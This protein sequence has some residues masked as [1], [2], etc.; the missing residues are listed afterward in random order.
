MNINTATRDQRLA[1]V[2]A[3]DTWE[4]KSSGRTVTITA[5]ERV[6]EDGYFTVAFTDDKGKARSRWLPYFLQNFVFVSRDGEVPIMSALVK[7]LDSWDDA[8]LARLAD[9]C[10]DTIAAR[11]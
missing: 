4:Q 10:R 8:F 2:Q 1:A 7:P 11:A 5:Q 9:A 3:G 6:T